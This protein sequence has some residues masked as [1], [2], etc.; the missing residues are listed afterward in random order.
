MNTDVLLKSNL[1][2]KTAGLIRYDW[3]NKGKI[4]FTSF[5][6]LLSIKTDIMYFIIIR[7]TITIYFNI[8]DQQLQYDNFEKQAPI[9]F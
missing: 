4:N 7:P 3:K 6:G 5:L 2:V 8:K 9:H 1:F